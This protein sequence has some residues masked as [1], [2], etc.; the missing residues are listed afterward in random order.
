MRGGW[1]SCSRFGWVLSGSA[2]SRGISTFRASPPTRVRT[3]APWRA[4]NSSVDGVANYRDLEAAAGGQPGARRCGDLH[5]AAGVTTKL[6]EAALDSGRHVLM[7]KPPC[8]SLAQLDNLVRRAEVARRTLYQTWH[9][10]H[11]RAV[12]P[13]ARLLEQA[14]SAS[15]AHHLEGGCPP[16]ASRPGLALGAGRVRRVRSGHERAV[17]SDKAHS[18]ADFS[19]R[20]AAV[21]AGELRGTDRGRGRTAH[22][23][24]ASGSHASFD[25][26]ETGPQRWNIDLETDEG[27]MHLSAGGGHLTLGDS[28]C[29]PIPVRWTPNMR[30]FT[31]A[32]H[33][34][35]PRAASR[36]RHAAATARVRYISRRE[37]DSGRVVRI[38]ATPWLT[39]LIEPSHVEITS[40]TAIPGPSGCGCT[41]RSRRTWGR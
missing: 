35:V 34:L 9:S 23:Y 38:L 18:R 17:D 41:G 1:K 29:P 19:A 4:R 15:G 5:A 3:R 33:E 11:A 6:R 28:R 27:A 31:R 7:E 21:R 32:L 26:R 36:C 24:A 37:A 2:R 40:R 20:R 30:P 22:G 10:Q 12:E 39:G 14:Q 25:F 8:A 13:A 16:L